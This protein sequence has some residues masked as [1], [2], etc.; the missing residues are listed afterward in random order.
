[1]SPRTSSPSFDPEGPTAQALQ[2]EGITYRPGHLTLRENGLLLS[3]GLTSRILAR[4]GQKVT[5]D[6]GGQSSVVF[7]G[8][9]DGAATFPLPDD[10]L[11]NPGGWV[12]VQ[13]SEMEETGKGGVGA[14]YFDQ[15]GNVTDYKMLLT[16]T[17]MNC[18][19]SCMNKGGKGTVHIIIMY[20]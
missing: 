11:V 8:R 1:M 12:F 14:L 6:T 18:A 13:N 16:G 19:V 17:T 15:Y 10:E 20:P 5:F 2:A 9:P 3:E 4:S 7:H